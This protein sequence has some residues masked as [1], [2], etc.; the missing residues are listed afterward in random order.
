LATALG[1]I[2]TLRMRDLNR[3]LQKRNE[4]K[5]E[6]PTRAAAILMTPFLRGKKKM[7]VP[8]RLF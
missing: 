1:E 4:L 2:K 8:D 3:V 6:A 5:E 7:T